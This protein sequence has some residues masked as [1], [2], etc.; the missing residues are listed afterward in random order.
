MFVTK[1]KEFEVENK[2]VDVCISELVCH[3]S[4]ICTFGRKNV[5]VYIY[6]TFQGK[7]LFG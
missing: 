6:P 2:A 4:G 3:K 1:K 7:A 5:F